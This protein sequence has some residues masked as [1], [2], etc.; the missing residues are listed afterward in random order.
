VKPWLLFAAFGL[1]GVLAGAGLFL[2]PALERARIQG[3]VR[4]GDIEAA[5]GGR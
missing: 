5:E 1:G 3:Y 2:V 4:V